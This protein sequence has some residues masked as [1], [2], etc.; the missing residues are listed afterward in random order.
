MDYI[1]STLFEQKH[2]KHIVLADRAALYVNG[3]GFGEKEISL[4]G[5]V[6]REKEGGRDKERIDVYFD[7]LGDTVRRAHEAGKRV[8]IMHGTPELGFDIKS[9]APLRPY[10]TKLARKRCAIERSEFEKRTG[11]YRERLTG[12]LR[13]HPEVGSADISSAL[14]D[15]E[16]CY[17]ADK[18][19]LYYMDGDRLSGWGV[20]H[21]GEHVAGQLRELTGRN[22]GG[23]RNGG[24]DPGLVPDRE[25]GR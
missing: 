4:A 3:S 22:P 15:T 6:L 23:Q 9:C 18:G 21:V 20:Q 16:L 2:V 8:S 19:I 5:W 14:C 11:A 13:E 24:V 17:G 25:G 10:V 1:L 12:F 7:A